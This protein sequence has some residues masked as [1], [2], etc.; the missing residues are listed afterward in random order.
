M[1]MKHHINLKSIVDNGVKAALPWMALLLVAVSGVAGAEIYKW[2]DKQGVQH[3][4]E[5]PPRGDKYE[6]I[7]PSYAP[8]SPP[9]AA[10]PQNT[11][12]AGKATDPDRARQERAHQEESAK[13]SRQNCTTVQQRLTDLESAR[14][15][16]FQDAEGNVK[17]LTEDERLAKVAETKKLIEEY[18]Q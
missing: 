5:Q 15:I 2:T 4:S 7:K 8:A 14:R 17:L 10:E 3:Y 6:K 13:I 18:C 12:S 16:N 1:K 9:V 11:P